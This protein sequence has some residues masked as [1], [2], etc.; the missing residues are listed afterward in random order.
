MAERLNKGSPPPALGLLDQHGGDAPAFVTQRT[1]ARRAELDGIRC[2]AVLAVFMAHSGYHGFSFGALGVTVFFVLSGYL[3]TTLLTNEWR[4]DGRFSFGRFY[5]R[6]VLR[7]YPALIVLLVVGALFYRDLG[8]GGTFAGYLRAAAAAGLYF[9]DF[10]WGL[11]GSAHGGFGNTWSLAVEE[12]F[13]IVWPLVL[14]G[15]LGLGWRRAPAC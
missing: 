2:F 7:L 9:Q 10:V 4:R 1:T 14:V 11:T 6:R 8:D 12:Q 13:Y 3:I 5:A 15:L